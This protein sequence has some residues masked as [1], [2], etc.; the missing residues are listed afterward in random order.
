MAGKKM[1]LIYDTDF[2]DQ[3]TTVDISR[4]NEAT[5]KLFKRERETMA[6]KFMGQ[7]DRPRNPLKEYSMRTRWVQWDEKEIKEMKEPFKNKCCFETCPNP[8]GEFGHNPAPFRFGPEARCCAEC[9]KTL[10]IPRRV[11]RMRGVET[12]HGF[13][14]WLNKCNEDLTRELLDHATMSNLRKD[15]I[16]A[17]AD[18]Q[19]K[20]FNRAKEIQELRTEVRAAREEA[21]ETRMENNRLQKK[22]EQM[23]TEAM[24]KE[25]A[26][27]KKKVCDLEQRLAQS[28]RN[29]KKRRK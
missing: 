7:E 12:A 29:N 11:M 18:Y 26:E 27:W 24:K 2:G 17:L 4:Y 19:E 9:N 8:Y 6:M 10:V 13:V 3:S 1:E 15:Q 20:Y 5:Q 14:Y 25:R 23:M 22:M 16:I 21:R 28:K